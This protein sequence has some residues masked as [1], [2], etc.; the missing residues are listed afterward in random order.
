MGAQSDATPL[1]CGFFE[2]VIPFSKLP[3]CESD[4]YE[5]CLNEAE[6]ILAGSSE[7]VLPIK[8]MWKQLA[9]EGKRRS[10]DVPSLTDFDALL[11]GDK[12]FEVISAQTD[13]DEVESL[14]SEDGEEIDANLGSLGFFPEDRVKLRRIKLPK[15]TQDNEDSSR[16]S[17]EEELGQLSVR[18]LSATKPV[19]KFETKKNAAKNSSTKV[20]T[21]GKPSPKAQSKKRSKRQIRSRGRVTKSKRKSR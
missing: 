18:G 6:R 8:R 4:M 7:V 10:Y 16:E 11:E 5:R 1:A 14:L 9:E 3:E 19:R 13:P 15:P 20:A 12:R 21:K 17:E 2:I